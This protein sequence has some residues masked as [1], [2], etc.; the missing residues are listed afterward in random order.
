MPLLSGISSGYQRLSKYITK[1]ARKRLPLSPKRAGKGFYKGNNC[2][3]TGRINSLGACVVY[4][5]LSLSP[6]LAGFLIDQRMTLIPDRCRPLPLTQAGS[7]SMRGS[8]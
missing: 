4:L 5:A 8:G 2:A 7:G 6:S 1:A 3:S